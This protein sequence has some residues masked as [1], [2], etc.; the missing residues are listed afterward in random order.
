MLYKFQKF[1]NQM[2]HALFIAFNEIQFE[3]MPPS[4][5]MSQ[6][7]VSKFEPEI[8]TNVNCVVSEIR[9]HLESQVFAMAWIFIS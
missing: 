9:V 3:E 5:R 6:K 1:F 2:S 7:L 8:E 4:A